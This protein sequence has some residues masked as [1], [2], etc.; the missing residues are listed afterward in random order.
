MRAFDALVG[1]LDR[2]VGTGAKVAVLRRYFAEAPAADAA[3]GLLLL[4]GRRRRL[5]TGRRLRE[6]LHRR[7]G[8]PDW[9]IDACQ[10]QVGD[11]AEMLAL[12]WPEV[13]GRLPAP[14][15]VG[16]GLWSGSDLEQRPLHWWMET[17]L[18]TLA[19]LEEEQQADAVVDLWRSLP[20][21]RHFLVN[22]LL[23][24]GFRVGVSSGLVSRALAEAWD[25]EVPLVLQRLMGGFEPSAEAYRTLTAPPSE[26]EQAGGGR[27]YPFF[28]ASPLDPARLSAT[29]VDDWWV[30]WKWDGIRGQLVRREDTICL[31]S[32]G[33]EL[34]NAAF[35]ELVALGG[36]LPSGTVLDGEVIC[37]APGESRPMGFA[38]LQ[39]R[40]GRR[41]VSGTLQRQLPVR[42]VAYDLLEQCGRDWRQRELRERRTALAALRRRLAHHDE[43]WRLHLSELWTLT[44]WD[45]LEQ[46]RQR[47]RA[48][49]A[50]GL[51]LKR[52]ASPY[53]SGRRRGHW[54][55]HKLDPMSLDA[56]LV[57]AQA[58]RGRRANLFTDYT[59]ALWDDRAGPGGEPGL[60]TFARAY[61]GLDQ[62]EI[63]DL[64]RWIRGHTIDRFG[65]ARAVA[66]EQVFEIGFEGI[67][68]SR[69][70]RCGLAVRFPRIL[71][72][73]RDKPAAEADR[74][75]TAR[76]LL[77]DAAP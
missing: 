61:S 60:V 26:G 57:Y 5:I 50:E 56:V 12:L 76:A 39:R 22:K 54:W 15:A 58:G 75:S 4:M 64:D 46:D 63:N 1:D 6:V 37:W 70:H 30:E 62:G 73:R 43:A 53:L 40:L 74:L 25:L 28:L 45:A 44:A 66:P 69:R 36:L 77:E 29:P 19:R 68:P 52:L 34:I 8:L 24:G 11:T 27:P 7:S 72:W 32:R 23:T 48:V 14:S 31:W 2:L 16:C 71:R 17:A 42:F 47:A 65:P 20:P 10:A 18:P 49:G 67:H 38:A 35:P 9:L 51:M 59:F 33:E 3:W 55:K 13:A 41:R 21:G